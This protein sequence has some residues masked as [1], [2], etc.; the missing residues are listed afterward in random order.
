MLR[1]NVLALVVVVLNAA[2]TDAPKRA[3]APPAAPPAP[4]L[5]IT[6][7]DP[8]SPT[9][10]VARSPT[11]L[12]AMITLALPSDAPSVANAET[13]APNAMSFDVRLAWVDQACAGKCLS[14]DVIA[15]DSARG[16][17]EVHQRVE[18]TPD[19]DRVVLSEGPSRDGSIHRVVFLPHGVQG[20]HVDD[21]P[22]LPPK[23]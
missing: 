11:S 10:G 4:V 12:G 23:T 14:V 15:R 2:C 1:R 22:Q 7:L 9:P 13:S 8:L 17:V 6:H 19:V 21:L 18:L 5:F 20:L 3:D 16:D